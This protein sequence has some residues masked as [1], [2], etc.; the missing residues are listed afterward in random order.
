MSAFFLS[1]VPVLLLFFAYM[2][3]FCESFF[4]MSSS[5]SFSK[6]SSLRDKISFLS[7]SRKEV[8]R[9]RDKNL[10]Q[11]KLDHRRRRRRL[12]ATRRTI[13]AHERERERERE[14]INHSNTGRAHHFSPSPF[15]SL[16]L[17]RAHVIPA[18]GFPFLKCL[19]PNEHQNT[20]Y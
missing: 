18:S 16:S 6:V 1:F 15:L 5:S 12:L 8:E 3:N 19:H 20:K 7:I 13:G 9:R 14:S 17:I 10:S 4:F 2:Y 11:Q